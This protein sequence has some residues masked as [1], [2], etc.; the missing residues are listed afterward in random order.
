MR[1]RGFHGMLAIWKKIR[2][3]PTATTDTTPREGMKIDEPPSK[4]RGVKLLS[5]KL[6]S[7]FAFTERDMTKP[8]KLLIRA[9]TGRIIVASYHGLLEEAC[10]RLAVT[11]AN[12]KQNLPNP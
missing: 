9:G 4:K 2:G 3:G 6:V 1:W 7:K 12:E 5:L 11:L 10:R 8:A